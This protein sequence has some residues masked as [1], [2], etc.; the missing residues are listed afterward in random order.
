MKESVPS[1]GETRR[2]LKS[3]PGK[4]IRAKHDL[5]SLLEY[6]ILQNEDMLK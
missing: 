5:S 2:S 1:K 3:P 6:T 4:N